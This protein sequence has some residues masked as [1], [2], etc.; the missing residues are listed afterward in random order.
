[1]VRVKK[2]VNALKK[3]RTKLKAAKGYRFARSKKERAAND[4]LLHA[5]L[6]AWR[7]RRL[8]KRVAR[9]EWTV[10]INAAVRA[11]GF[12]NYSTFM[13]LLKTKNITLDRKV[14]AGLAGETPTIFER[15]MKIATA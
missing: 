1:M 7:D 6:H 13:A 3:R 12:K 11:L 10:R 5:G 2:G 4:A 9:S 8:K 15:F 14:L